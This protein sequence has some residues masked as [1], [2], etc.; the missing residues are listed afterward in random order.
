V[1]VKVAEEI[2]GAERE[3]KLLTLEDVYPDFIGSGFRSEE[4]KI[5]V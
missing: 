3:G 1:R 2:Y 5:F 4:H